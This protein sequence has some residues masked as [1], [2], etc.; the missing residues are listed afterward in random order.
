MHSVAPVPFSLSAYINPFSSLPFPLIFIL[1]QPLTHYLSVVS[2]SPRP[3]TSLPPPCW[4]Q[5]MLVQMWYP[6]T[7]ATVSREFKK[8]LAKHL[9]ATSGSLE[10]LDLKL[11][12]FGYRGVS[13]QEVSQSVTPCFIYSAAAHVET[14]K[15]AHFCIMTQ[16]LLLYQYHCSPSK[17]PDQLNSLQ[18]ALISTGNPDASSQRSK[19]SSCD[20]FSVHMAVSCWCYQIIAWYK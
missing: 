13:S 1:Y 2:L 11:H 20:I 15:R 7:V 8:I 3:H 16:V 6:I 5:T 12:D 10:G 18:V 9:K 17:E 4:L 19:W 14:C